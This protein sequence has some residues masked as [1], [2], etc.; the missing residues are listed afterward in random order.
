MATFKANCLPKPFL[1]LPIMEIKIKARESNCYHH[2][3][4]KH[5]T[6]KKC[7]E[8]AAVAGLSVPSIHELS[9][10]AAPQVRHTSLIR[11]ITHTLAFLP[12]SLPLMAQDPNCE[13]VLHSLMLTT[14]TTPNTL[15]AIT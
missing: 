4:E 10:V 9:E 1:K 2:T 3:L 15:P 7:L 11:G 13:L 12:S 8:V 6:F 5:T 14:T